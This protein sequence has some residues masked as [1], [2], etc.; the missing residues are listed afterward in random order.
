MDDLSDFERTEA[1]HDGS[2]KV[3]YRKGNGPGVVVMAEMP[4]ITPTVADFARK[5]VGIGCTVA[6]PSLFGSDGAPLSN[7]ALL[8]TM[9]RACISNEFHALAT[10][11]AS[12]VTVWL[13]SLAASLH[14]E[15]GG[16]GVGAIGMCF[17]GGFA[18]AMMVDDVVVAPVLSQPSLPL[19]IGAK[20]AA[21][22]GISASDLRI[23]KQRVDAGC[24]VLGLRFTE[25]RAVGTRFDTLRNEL[26]D[27]FI[28]V[29]LDS[30]PDNPAGFAKSAHSVVTTEVVETPGHPAYEAREQVLDFFRTRLEL[31]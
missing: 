12:P 25:D 17:T 8:K 14:E 6:M 1:T 20:R 27:G 24:P 16:P 15:C 7:P 10:G 31:A 30:S 4:G 26:G 18:L 9:P 23:V 3:V 11:K 28:A 2:T 19:A 13:R 29:E 22:L 21:D 5:V